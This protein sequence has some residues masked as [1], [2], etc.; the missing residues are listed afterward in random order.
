MYACPGVPAALPPLL[1][2]WPPLPCIL[3][4]ELQ[5]C[6]LEADL[7]VLPAGADTEIGEKG[8]NLS[9]G[10]KQRIAL[11]RALYKASC[12]HSSRRSGSGVGSR[13]GSSRGSRL[14]TLSI[15]PSDPPLH[16]LST[17]PR[18]A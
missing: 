3:S 2:P 4:C 18:A 16:P 15:L 10:Q 1:T 8:I 11:A 9:G 5:A 12:L 14:P 6:C 7:E 17:L 13:R